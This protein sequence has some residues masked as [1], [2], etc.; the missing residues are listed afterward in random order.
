MDHILS[1]LSPITR[2]PWFAPLAWLSFIQ[3][4]KAVWL[5]GITDSMDVTLSE[6]REMVTDREA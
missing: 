4:A 3:L 5:D 2:T 6:L 1:D